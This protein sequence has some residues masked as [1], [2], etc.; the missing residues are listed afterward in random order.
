MSPSSHFRSPL[1]I[2]SKVL[3]VFVFFFFSCKNYQVNEVAVYQSADVKHL[4]ESSK[5]Q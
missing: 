5:A 1:L 2:T 4:A 3:P